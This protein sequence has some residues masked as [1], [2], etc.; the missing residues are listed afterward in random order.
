MT[1]KEL[2]RMES[3]E[4]RIK[5]IAEEEGLHT[6]D[7]MFEVVPAR[8]MIEAMAYHF[9]TNFSHWTFGRD[10]DRT[11]T[12]YDHTGTGIPYEVVWNFETPRAFLVASN[13]FTLN[14]L[15]IAHV[16]GHVDHFLRNR[17]FQHGRSFADIAEE[18]RY[19]AKRFR[20]YENK[21]GSE[22]V[23]KIIDAALTIQWQQHPDPFH[24]EVDT[25]Q[26]RAYL[27]QKEKEKIR[28]LQSAGI[29]AKETHEKIAAAE[30]RLRALRDKLPPEPVFDLLKFAIDHA[31]KLRN[32]ERDVLRRIRNQARALAPHRRVKML[33]EGWATYWHEI[34]MRRLF[35]E[36]LLTPEEHGVYLD[37]HA[38]VTRENKRDLNVYCVGPMI[39]KYV[40]HRWDKGRLGKSY[41]ECTDPRKKERWD[42]GAGKGTEKIF[43]VSEY[44]TDRMS[45]EEF[46]TDEFIHGMKL[47]I[48]EAMRDQATGDI[49]YRVIERRAKVIRR[50]LLNGYALYNMPVI[51]VRD[52]NFADQGEWYLRHHYQGSELEV[53]NRDGA[54]GGLHYIWRRKVHLETVIDDKPKLV[55]F[56][57]EDFSTDE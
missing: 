42:I 36:G 21:Y 2:K 16:Y 46:F 49:V 55:S 50:M 54:L 12:I 53:R 41:D 38:K 56:D 31:P 23:E 13:P 34:I 39:F 29:S 1:E 33:A 20:E 10:Y 48:Y 45:I 17:Y 6:T 26:A 11:R 7:I 37:F 40:K 28:A 30:E 57:G 27:M 43:E 5:E 19:T 3:L 44:Y 32:W 22:S 52:G 18:A 47:Y 14:V 24:E 15:T 4:A 25:E 51:S 9:P 8:R 35:D